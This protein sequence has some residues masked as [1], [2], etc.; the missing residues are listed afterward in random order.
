MRSVNN[1]VPTPPTL[2]SKVITGFF[3]RFDIT[4]SFGF[5]DFWQGRPFSFSIKMF[6]R[7]FSSKDRAS[8]AA[9]VSKR[10]YREHTRV[11]MQ[12]KMDILQ[13]GRYVEPS[14]AMSNHR[15]KWLILYMMQHLDQSH[16]HFGGRARRKTVRLS[17]GYPDDIS[18]LCCCSQKPNLR[19][20]VEEGRAA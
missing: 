4:V 3:S 18:L 16:Y 6:K 7:S 19:E 8:R 10:S 9:K 17:R 1:P 14:I 12:P 13:T 15:H 5:S 11:K 2:I 20:R